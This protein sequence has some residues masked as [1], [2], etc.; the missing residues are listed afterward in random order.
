MT[1]SPGPG[2]TSTPGSPRIERFLALGP[3]RFGS[4][5]AYSTSQ[6]K[7]DFFKGLLDKITCALFD[8]VVAEAPNLRECLATALKNDGSNG[9]FC[10]LKQHPNMKIDSSQK[11]NGDDSRLGIY[12]FDPNQNRM[13]LSMFVD[14]ISAAI[15]QTY[16]G[17]SNPV[18]PIESID[19]PSSKNK[20][21]KVDEII[22]VCR[23]R[24]S[25]TSDVE[26]FVVN[27]NLEYLY[28]NNV[29]ATTTDLDT[30]VR[31][32]PL[33]DFAVFD[34][35]YFSV[36]WWRTPAALD[37]IPV[38]GPMLGL[39]TAERKAEGLHRISNANGLRK[40]KAKNRLEKPP[41]ATLV[42]PTTHQAQAFMIF[43]SS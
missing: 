24:N 36:F 41:K 34:L 13:R 18:D 16:V 22:D 12:C 5:F 38:R 20:S 19:S 3:S 15:S 7:P 6:D 32:G 10:V 17:R 11:S 8:Q 42:S 37:Y 21:S 25:K 39:L 9:Q 26:Y 2:R 14:S 35:D 1:G 43:A 4:P 27:K 28:I 23:V 33:P 30:A 31:A 29:D 40:T